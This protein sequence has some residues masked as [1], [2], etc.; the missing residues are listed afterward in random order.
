MAVFFAGGAGHVTFTVL[1]TPITDEFRATDT[2]LLGVLMVA[3]V[4]SALLS[5][6]LGKAVDRYGGRVVI[7][8]ALVILASMLLLTAQAGTLWQFYL[9]YSMAFAFSRAGVWAVSGPAIAANWFYRKRGVAFA[10]IMGVLALITVP[11]PII[12]QTMVDWLDWR[13][14]WRLVALGTFAVAIPVA[15]LVI[16][17]KPENMGLRPD[18]ARAPVVAQPRER[19]LESPLS[20]DESEEVSWTLKEAMETRTFWLLNGGY[21]LIVFPMSSIIVVMHTYFTEL[22]ISAGTASRLVSTFGLSSFIGTFVMGILIQ[23]L[24]VRRLLAP[25]AAGY[26]VS[27]VLFTVLAGHTSLLLTYLSMLP[28]GLSIMGVALVGN[29]VW[30]DYYGRAAIGTILGLHNLVRSVPL[31]AGPLLA[32]GIRDSW[33]DYRIAFAV[34]AGFCFLGA[35]GLLFARPPRKTVQ[36]APAR[37]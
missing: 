27:I 2:E 18:G 6:F 8:V 4:L 22:D 24:S 26:G 12:A 29:Q 23:K 1:V 17:S 25:L 33:G 5:P 9:A 13:W 7:V 10:V 21:F 15:W 32:A 28:L 3:G 37:T 16:R 11:F 31:A 35:V 34:F 36:G 19:S 20:A 30:A 14:A